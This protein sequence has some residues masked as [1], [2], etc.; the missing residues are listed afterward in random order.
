MIHKQRPDLLWKLSL[1][2]L[3]CLGGWVFHHIYKPAK[4]P[5]VLMPPSQQRLLPYLVVLSSEE[6]LPSPVQTPSATG[7]WYYMLEATASEDKTS[8]SLKLCLRPE[9]SYQE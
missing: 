4:A 2:Q 8:G 6:T 9:V 1:A 5:H 7:H 3:P